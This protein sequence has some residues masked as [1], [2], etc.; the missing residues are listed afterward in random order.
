MSTTDH[1]LTVLNTYDTRNQCG[2]SHRLINGLKVVPL[3]LIFSFLTWIPVRYGEWTEDEIEIVCKDRAQQ[4]VGFKGDPDF[5]G[6]GIHI[7]LYLQW[8]SALVTNWFTPTER[9]AIVTTYIVFSVSIT[10][11]ILV[12]IFSRQCNVVAEMFVVLTIF[13]GGLNVV[14]LPLLHAAL[15]EGLVATSIETTVRRL[16][17][18]SRDSDGLKWSMSLLNYFMSLI[19]IW[20]WARLAAVRYQN[21]HS[22]P[23]SSSIYCFA[24]ISN[25]SIRAFS[26]FMSIISATHPTWFNYVSLPLGVDKS[27]EDEDQGSV[28][29]A[30]LVRCLHVLPFPVIPLLS[31]INT[32][33]G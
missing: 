4:A 5:Y 25:H 17:L 31:L 3:L 24:R 27:F 19:T 12:K 11:A 16:A 10:V 32:V 2:L 7:G 9:K 23:G 28:A 21:F 26:S 6:L 22:T 29:S 30:P 1:L 15:F 14:L 20:F 13:W 33:S 8:T 18:R